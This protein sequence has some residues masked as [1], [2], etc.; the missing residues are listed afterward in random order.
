MGNTMAVPRSASAA[1]TESRP[2]VDV[3]EV[4][5]LHKRNDWDGVSKFALGGRYGGLLVDG[6]LLEKREVCIWMRARL[7]GATRAGRGEAS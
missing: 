1:T 5:R 4:F 7:C 3:Q 6:S 2:M